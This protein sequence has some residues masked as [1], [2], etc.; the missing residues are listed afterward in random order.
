LTRSAIT[1][2]EFDTSLTKDFVATLGLEGKRKVENAIQENISSKAKLYRK[3]YKRRFDL[4]NRGK[5]SGCRLIY[6]HSRDELIVVFIYLYAKNEKENL[7]KDE[8]EYLK[9]V[10]KELERKYDEC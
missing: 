2:I 8:M 6:W 1:F 9:L 4:N 3:T 5:R 10:V 7:N